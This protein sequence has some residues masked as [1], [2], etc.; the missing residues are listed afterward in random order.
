MN[1][2]I[3]TVIPTFKRPHL[4]KRAIASVLEQDYE[5]IEIY[6][7]DN[8]SQ[9]ETRS[10]VEEFS[11]K[12]HRVKYFCHSENIGS[13]NNFLYGMSRVTGDYFSLLS[14]D[15]YL[16]PNFYQQAVSSLEKNNNA[17]FWAGMSLHIDENNTI[18]DARIT[19]WP[20]EGLF[21][22]PEG[23]FLM[24]GGMA[25]AWTS[26]LFRKKAIDLIGC[27]D[28]E[29]LGPSDL[30]YCLRLAA[31]YPY[32]IEKQPAAVFF[33]NTQ[34]F[35]ATQPMSS[36]W[37]GWLRMIEKLSQ[38][39]LLEIDFRNEITKTLWKDA[40]KMLFRRGA[41]A[42]AVARFD[43]VDDAA[44]ALSKNCNKKFKANILIILNKICKSIPLLQK[45]Y[46]RLYRYA[47]S[48]IV[49][50]RKE[51]QQQYGHLLK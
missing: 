30:D 18:W 45:A 21:T 23:F 39:D 33:L 43:F 46:S 48:K 17:I 4:L 34:S 22:P 7:Y 10:V 2:L 35:S 24:T 27:I 26:I 13:L 9:D 37:P 32:V 38:N 1:P 20:R 3:T 25:P 47:E 11:K 41:N 49:E 44:R 42:L 51:L 14:D 8:N 40:E 6:I 12:D 28:I 31:Q 29:T 5:N 50:S 19:R 16:L 15:D 36:F